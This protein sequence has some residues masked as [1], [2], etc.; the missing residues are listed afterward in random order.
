MPFCHLRI[1]ALRH[2]CPNYWIT[3]QAYPA[4][5]KTIGDHIRKRR[6]ELH[7]LQKP[8]AERLGVNIETLKIWE[9]GAAMPMIRHLPAVIEFLGIDPEPEPAALPERI[10]F[11]RR[12]LGWTQEK[13]AKA[14]GLNVSTILRW[15]SGASI[16]APRKLAEFQARLGERFLLIPQ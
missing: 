15:E 10:A 6:L 11:G 4:V 13:L 9:R 16:P 2:P 12:K 7:I 1:K 8:L 5:P 3:T 14:V